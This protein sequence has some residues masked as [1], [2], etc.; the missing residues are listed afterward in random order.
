MLDKAGYCFAS[1]LG[2]AVFD[3]SDCQSNAVGIDALTQTAIDL[4]KAREEFFQCN[5][6]T[7]RT[8]LDLDP[9]DMARRRVLDIQPVEETLWQFEHSCVGYVGDLAPIHSAPISTAPTIGTVQP[10][11]LLNF[12]RGTWMEDARGNAIDAD[13][14]EPAFPE[15]IFAEVLGSADQH[16]AGWIERPQGALKLAEFGGICEGVAG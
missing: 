4:I 11:A 14:I 10:G 8:A 3:N 15:W 5:V 13:P 7:S 16:V 6:D 12:N 2:Q 9:Q 1:P